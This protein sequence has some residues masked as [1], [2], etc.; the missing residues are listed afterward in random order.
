[1]GGVVCV[2]GWTYSTAPPART[3]ASPVSKK[4]TPS[5]LAER[6]AFRFAGP[7]LDTAAPEP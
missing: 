2:A 6:V 4:T 3:Q 7:H 5:G 1:M